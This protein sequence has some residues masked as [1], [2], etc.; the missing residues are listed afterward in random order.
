MNLE[1]RFGKIKFVCTDVDGVLTDGSLLYGSE[2]GHWKRFNVRDGAGVKALQRSGVPVAF[3]SG[4]HCAATIQRAEDLD[5]VD[6]FLGE[7]DKAS[8]V[9]NLSAKYNVPLDEI[10]FVGDD[11]IDLG[12]L[13]IVGLAV[14]PRDAVSE[15][16]RIAH[17]IAPVDGGGGVLRAVAEYILKSKGQWGNFLNFYTKLSPGDDLLSSASTFIKHKLV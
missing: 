8:I 9:N 10:A 16:Q 13:E 6:C 12:A 7:S 3:I 15:V 2:K 4:L 17:W 11:L 5:I 14:C 1:Q